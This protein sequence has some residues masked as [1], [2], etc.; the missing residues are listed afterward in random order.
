MLVAADIPAAL[1]QHVHKDNDKK[2]VT[3]EKGQPSRR[4]G[5]HNAGHS[6]PIRSHGGIVIR[7]PTQAQP[8]R[9]PREG[10][11]PRCQ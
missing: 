4:G 9:I 2:V 7:E 11:T 8:Q 10:G 1:P 3:Y 5:S 6:R